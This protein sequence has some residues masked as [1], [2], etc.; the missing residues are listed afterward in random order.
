MEYDTLPVTSRV[1]VVSYG[2]FRGLKGTVRR[3]DRMPY[4][5]DPFYF[6]HIELEGAYVKEAIWFV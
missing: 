3:V 2:P 1:R 5:D 4:Q 6:Y